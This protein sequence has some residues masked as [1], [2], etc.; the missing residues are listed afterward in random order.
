[1]A[2]STPLNCGLS[3][4]TIE[5]WVQ[6]DNAL[7]ARRGRDDDRV[8]RWAR[9]RFD[10]LRRTGA[11][12]MD[13]RQRGLQPLSECLGPA[14]ERRGQRDP[15]TSRSATARTARLGSIATD[16]PTAVRT[17]RRNHWPF[18]A[19]RGDDSLRSAAHARRR[20][21]GA[22]RDAL[23]A[24]LYD[25]ALE[26]LRDRSLGGELPRLHSLDRD[27]R[28]SDA[29]A[30]GHERARLLDRDRTAARPRRRPTRALRRRAAEAGRDAHG[31]SRA[32]R[33]SPERL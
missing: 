24:R 14:G 1:M 26:P 19:G 33:I 15:C 16:C 29:R 27:R 9:L 22:G 12:P 32:T 6:L 8:E 21:P 20:Q 18:R 7:A 13:G 28:R 5:V 10:R 2:R 23:R 25:R 30:T 11:G 3:S 4:K 31:D 17:R